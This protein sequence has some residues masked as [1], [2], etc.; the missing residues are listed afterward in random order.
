MQP[1]IS[2]VRPFHLEDLFS[3][4][5]ASFAVPF[6]DIGPL[7][8][9]ARPVLVDDDLLYSFSR[10][11]RYWRPRRRTPQALPADELPG[12]PPAWTVAR[13]PGSSRPIGSLNVAFSAKCNRSSSMLPSFTS[14]S[15]FRTT[16]SMSVRSIPVC[17]RAGPD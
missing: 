6:R 12:I 14:F 11:G 2:I 3:A 13:S 8:R 16:S 5:A 17:F 15:Y 7:I 1:C 10:F 9:G 4:H